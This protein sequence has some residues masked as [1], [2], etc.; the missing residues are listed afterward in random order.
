M[1]S[2]RHLDGQVCR[3]VIASALALVLIPVVLRESASPNPQWGNAIQGIGHGEVTDQEIDDLTAGIGTGA[4]ASGH[5]GLN[6]A[7]GTG[8]LQ[9]NSFSAANP[10]T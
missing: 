1:D 9:S 5:V 8:N 2:S 4:R 10:N 6:H 3:R 7:A